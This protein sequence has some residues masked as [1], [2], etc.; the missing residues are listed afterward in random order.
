MI[1]VNCSEIYWYALDTECY[2]DFDCIDEDP[3][4]VDFCTDAGTSNSF[5]TNTGCVNNTCC[6]INDYIGDRYCAPIGE[7]V[8]QDYITYTCNLP[9][10]HGSYCSDETEARFIEDCWPDDC[11]DGECV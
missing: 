7:V 3:C 9:G 1:D 11:L 5:C 10:E 2:D 6:G 8:Y 4:N